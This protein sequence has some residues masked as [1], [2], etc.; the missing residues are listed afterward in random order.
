[1]EVALRPT[2]DQFLLEVVFPAF[3]LGVVS[4]APALEHLLR[5]LNDEAT[6]VLIELVLEQSV[7]D[8]FFGL[9]DERWNEAV[10]RLLFYEWIKDGD[11]WVIGNQYIGHA[12]PWEETFHLSLMLE[13]AT[14]P[15]AES[16]S[17]ELGRRTFWGQPQKRYGISTLLTG[18]WDP[19]PN[20][21]PDQVLTSAGNGVYHPKSGIARAD[22]SWRPMMAV[23]S[24][25]SRMPS[26][27]NNLLDREVRRL[28]PV[29]VPEKHEVLDFWLG[30]IKEPP[31]L[32]VSFSGLG[33]RAHEW[34][35]DI[36]A[37]AQLV[38]TA[39]DQH[40]GLSAVISRR[41]FTME[42]VS[43]PR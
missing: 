1:M 30:R 33:P 10:Y 35:R 3:E 6:R 19:V 24:W 22:W 25:A 37:L 34:I 5:K 36:G 42:S 23:S 11:G 18:T 4:A 39:A 9:S 28:R 15:Y 14:Y 16:S 40:Q 17:A 32:A 31:V 7:E 20:F 8:T 21:P 26:M 27:L 2:N 13:D 29:S 41:L 38:R 43:D 12:G